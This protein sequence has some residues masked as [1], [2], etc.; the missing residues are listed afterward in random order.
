M[1]N[2]CSVN[3]L[4][5]VND[6]PWSSG[7]ALSAWRFARAAATVG[8]QTPVVFFREDGVYNALPGRVAD[9]GTPNLAAAWRTLA[10]T[11]GTRLLVCRTSLDRRSEAGPVAPFEVSGLTILFEHLL[12]CDRTVSF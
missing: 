9:A 5:I 4:I 3:C 8:L 12:E 7:R 1:E 6:G 10:E 11:T 2:K